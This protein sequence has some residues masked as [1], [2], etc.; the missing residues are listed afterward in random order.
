[1]VVL[2]RSSWTSWRPSIIEIIEAIEIFYTKY[3]SSS[4]VGA[5]RLSMDKG[6]SFRSQYHS[7][8]WLITVS[9]HSVSTGVP[10]GSHLGLCLA[11]INDL[12]ALTGPGTDVYA[13]DTIIRQL[14][15]PSRIEESLPVT[16]N[17]NLS[18]RAIGFVMERSV[19]TYKDSHPGSWSAGKRQRGA[20]STKKSKEN[21]I[22]LVK[23]HKHLGVVQADDLYSSAHITHVLAEGKRK[24]GF[25]CYRAKDFPAD[26]VSTLYTTYVRPT[27]GYASPV[28]HG[29]L[30]KQLSLALER[31]QASVAR[32]ILKA[33]WTTPKNVHVLFEQLQWPSL[34]WRWFVAVAATCLL[35]QLLQNPTDPLKDFLFLFSSTVSSYNFCKPRQ[36][37]FPTT[38]TYQHLN[39]FF[40]PSAL[41]WNSLPASIQSTT[42]PNHFRQALTLQWIEHKI[43][44]NLFFSWSE[45]TGK[46]AAESRKSHC[47]LATWATGTWGAFWV[48]V[49]FR[50]LRGGGES[51]VCVS[52]TFCTKV[53]VHRRYLSFFRQL[54]VRQ[55]SV[56][57]T[58]F[59]LLQQSKRHKNN[60]VP[61]DLWTQDVQTSAL[62][63]YRTSEDIHTK[64]TT[65]DTNYYRCWTPV[66]SCFLWFGQIHNPFRWQPSFLYL[67]CFYFLKRI[68][69]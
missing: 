7:S 15:I 39:S 1:M 38:R 51:I 61:T 20:N 14:L 10:Q 30:S 49:T 13:D 3:S 21:A 19:W 31:V 66:T 28:W 44:T 24:P 2:L 6:L 36:P 45:V 4:W 54:F 37:I 59:S 8:S 63:Y 26:L 9:K 16:A 18:R 52:C 69:L 5:V 47:S 40:Y 23:Q 53:K 62:V 43:N 29:G 48:Q 56:N 33:P 32:W 42:K 67:Q 68:G 60:W 25:L 17:I 65:T 12:S 58:S 57:Q 27:L 64:I 34:S 22:S 46:G 55:A 35:R 11:F 41:L 50:R